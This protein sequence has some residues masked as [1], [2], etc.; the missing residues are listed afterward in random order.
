[1]REKAFVPLTTVLVF[2]L[3]ALAC[4]SRGSIGDTLSVHPVAPTNGAALS[5]RSGTN[6]ARPVFVWTATPDA[7]RF[8]LQV[9]DS[10]SSTQS[11]DFPSPEID[12]QNVTQPNYQA[13][14]GLIPNA[15]PPIPHRYYWHVRACHG[16]TCGDWSPVRYVVVGVTAGFLNTDINGDGYEDAVVGAPASNAGG[17][18]AGSAYVY[19]GGK[20]VS[21][22]PALVLNHQTAFEEFGTSVAMVGDVNGDGFGDYLVRSLGDEST[23]GV[24]PQAHAYIYFGA[25]A[26]HSTPDVVLD[27][28]SVD[29]ENSAAAGIGDVN[30][31]GYDDVAIGGS[32]VDAAHHAQFPSRVEIHFGGPSMANTPDLILLGDVGPVGDFFGSAVAAGAD[33]NGDGYPDLV[34]GSHQRVTGSATGFARVYFG[35]PGLHQDPDVTIQSPL[36]ADVADLFGFAVAGVGDVNGDGVADL[37][38]GAPATNASMA[39][40]GTV[41]VYFGGAAFGTRSPDVTLKGANQGDRFGKVVAGMGDI[42]GDGLGD[43]AILAPAIQTERVEIFLGSKSPKGNADFTFHAGPATN[44]AR[45][46]S[47]RDLDGDSLPDVLVGN[48]VTDGS[49]IGRASVLL[50]AE[51]YTT[52]AFT[53]S[54]STAGDRF[55]S[56]I[57]R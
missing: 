30:G 27:C 20:E 38:V 23:P 52:S 45:G 17:Q 54:G 24:A 25:A 31:D 6:A 40:L 8:E 32:T 56:A 14:T 12:E 51:G 55:G 44:E 9:D 22:T 10:C 47:V 13:T 1:M 35:G 57:A 21:T 36:G 3:L 53:V 41:Y 7:G 5:N 34:V 18:Q 49:G 2:P 46:L 39:P 15:A 29:D 28:G 11:C 16:Q 19:L 26:L 33:L 37:A 4:D 50:G 42:D 43:I 48:W